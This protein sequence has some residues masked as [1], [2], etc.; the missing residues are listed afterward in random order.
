MDRL[1]VSWHALMNSHWYL[2]YGALLVFT[3]LGMYFYGLY[4]TMRST[5]T[6]TRL[7]S[8]P[9]FSS[10]A[11][12]A[13]AIA[14]TGK[15]KQ[16]V[17]R[18]KTIDKVRNISAEYG[19][20]LIDNEVVREYCKVCQFRRGRADDKNVPATYPETLFVSLIG[21]LAVRMPA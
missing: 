1:A 11:F 12:K 15:Q 18:C 21:A 3:F 10:L 6:N 5:E 9:T 19:S 17:L 8:L 7:K 2:Q 4:L 14:V 16:G 13:V 20:I